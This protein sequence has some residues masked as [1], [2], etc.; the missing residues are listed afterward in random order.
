MTIR[1]CACSCGQLH[2]A[3]EGE[4]VRISMCHCLECPRRTGAVISNQ[5]RYWREQITFAGK[6]TTWER[7]AESGNGLT[8]YF[9]PTCG[10]TVYW[11]NKGFPG[12]V[13]V[14]IGNLAG[15][16]F[17]APAIG[18]WEDRATPGSLC[19]PTLLPNAWRSKDDKTTRKTHLK[20]RGIS[21]PHLRS[22]LGH[23]RPIG[24]LVECPI[25]SVADIAR[26][27]QSSGFTARQNAFN[28]LGRV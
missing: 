18:V 21:S 28:D 13:A 15:A 2:L 23:A 5:A 3:I 26:V 10:S 17:P 4:S 27:G 19:R 12:Y 22:A 16:N 9:C 8:F 11:E 24:A 14:A 20:F 25:L 7:T 1:H 6:A